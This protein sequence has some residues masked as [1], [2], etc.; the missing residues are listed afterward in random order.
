MQ[1][2]GLFTLPLLAVAC[3]AALFPSRAD[4][5]HRGEDTVTISSEIPIPTST[6]HNVATVTET[7]HDI[8]TVTNHVVETAVP[9]VYTYQISENEEP[10]LMR[11]DDILL[12]R[13]VVD[14]ITANGTLTDIQTV[15]NSA[16][17]I[18]RKKAALALTVGLLMAGALM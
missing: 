5:H 18:Q 11:D 1:I 14:V 17:G 13:V 7:V 12:S 2:K 6:V 16:S 10:H 8:H 3:Q 9:H 15:K 4:H